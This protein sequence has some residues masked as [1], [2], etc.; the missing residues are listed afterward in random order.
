MRLR[1]H[2]PLAAALLT[3]VLTWATA[4][5]ASDSQIEINQASV[6]AAGGFPLVLLQRAATG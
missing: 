2:L 4:A 3:L 1:A 5:A 6:A